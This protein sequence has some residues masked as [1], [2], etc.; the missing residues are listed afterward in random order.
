MEVLNWIY[1][2]F[3]G[4]LQLLFEFIF[5]LSN[6]HLNNPG[7]TIIL[8]SLIVNLLVLPLY[9]RADKL[10]SEERYLE[11]KLQPWVNHI[12]ATFTGDERF[13][14]LQ[15]Y[16]RQNNYN[17]IFALKGAGTLLLEIP[18]F[19]A[20][21][22]FLSGLLLLQGASFGPIKD[23]SLPDKLFSFGSI[24]I[25]L[26]PILMTIINIVSSMIYLKDFPLR[27]KIQTYGLAMLFLFV[28]Y[29]SPSGLVCYWIF[30][31][32][33]SLIKN[34]FYKL[35]N[36]GKILR[37]CGIGLAII[38]LVFSN[39]MLILRPQDTMRNKII[40]AV[41]ILLLYIIL[42]V[43]INF[44][45]IHLPILDEKSDKKGLFYLG[46]LFLI[47]LTGVLIP[48][49]VIHSSVGDFSNSFHFYSPVKYIFHSA[50][51]AIGTFGIWSGIFYHLASK[52]SK[53]IME[54]GFLILSGTSAV[55]YM[56][57]GT[58]YGDLTNTLIYRT[59]PHDTNQEVLLNIVIFFE[60]CII[61]LLL[62]KKKYKFATGVLLS[63]CLAVGVMSSINIKDIS[64][65][66]NKINNYRQTISPEITLSKNGKNV[67]I[68]ML[69]RAVGFYA[70]F[71]F[72]EK[73]ELQQKFDGFTLYP[74]TL[75]FGHTTN[76]ALPAVYGGYEYTPSVMNQRSD[77]SL[78]TKHNEALLMMPILF[79]KENYDV[80]VIEPTY[81][82]YQEVPDL[83]IYKDYPKIKAFLADGAFTDLSY[84]QGT[85]NLLNRN[86]FCFS[87]F[88]SVPLAVQPVMYTGGLYNDPDAIAKRKDDTQILQTVDDLYTAH[89]KNIGLIDTYLVLDNLPVITNITDNN[90]NTYLALDNRTSHEPTLLQMPDYEVLSTVDNKPY[91][92]SQITRKSL[93]GRAIIIG[94]TNQITHYHINMLSFLE[95]A[96]WM[97]Y[98]REHDVYDN[99]RIII[100]ADH[101]RALGFDDYVLYQGLDIL[102]YNP[103][104]MVKDF[105]SREFTINNQ[106][107]T[108][109]DVP[110]IAMKGIIES[111]VNPFTGNAINDEMKNNELQ[112]VQQ[113]V[114]FRPGYNHGNTFL[115][116]PWYNVY[117]D[118]IF[119]R[120]NWESID[121]H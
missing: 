93:D 116:S 47:I 68:L 39:I 84:R 18:F 119:I 17:P 109:A 73:P 60:L 53:K 23:L 85:I 81:A 71:I 118:N 87:L 9:H 24:S 66:I 65:D 121:I 46:S 115:P 20:A 86:F 27:N 63:S 106:F 36:P 77:L 14:I 111:P 61:L 5:S 58:K 69:D 38:G 90:Q 13:M 104:F 30:N 120:D 75:S 15:T 103:L 74:N 82:N 105:N 22:S 57:F 72:A 98:L 76:I 89:G 56:F 11:K 45:K 28:L 31:N 37:Y 40:I 112:E 113:T 25:N 55:N 16:Y 78:I 114:E 117:G 48:S 43:I 4:P 10:Q 54:F 1:T 19:I 64:R 34:I 32:I 110:A 49:S 91:E 41:V 107:M 26:L 102:A 29:N 8:L 33:F 80:T 96:K 95:I 67:V 94:T 50:L 79:G 108:N 51:Y 100:V 7:I 21:Y 3:I 70:P 59:P 97:D 52:L 83:R 92:G 62:G 2:L 44:S 12:K 42:F 99:T 6:R 35:K 101:G 88:K